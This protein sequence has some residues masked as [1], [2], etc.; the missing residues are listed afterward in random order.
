MAL[1]LGIIILGACAFA[2][3]VIQH[4]WS[5]ISSSISMYS[6]GGMSRGFV[7]FLIN[8]RTLKGVK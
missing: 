1:A 6:G 8:V 5:S 7:A 2:R 3:G 4:S